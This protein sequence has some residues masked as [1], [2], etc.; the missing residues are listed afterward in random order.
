MHDESVQ[1]LFGSDGDSHQPEGLAID[2][3]AGVTMQ[4]RIVRPSSGW[5]DDLN[6]PAWPSQRR[7]SLRNLR[8]GD[9][10]LGGQ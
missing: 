4:F 6:T 3:P 5:L 2:P 8:V 1:I 9:P 10:G 7:G